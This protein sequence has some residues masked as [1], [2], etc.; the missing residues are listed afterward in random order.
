MTD[1]RGIAQVRERTYFRP[2]SPL[3]FRKYSPLLAVMQRLCNETAHF[4]PATWYRHPSTSIQTSQLHVHIS[5][6]AWYITLSGDAATK[7]MDSKCGHS[8]SQSVFSSELPRIFD[9]D[10]N[11][12]PE[13][14]KR[15]LEF[16]DMTVLYWRNAF[17]SVV[18]AFFGAEIAPL[19]TPFYQ[20][21]FH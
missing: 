20:L 11:A 15:L 7:R 17:L 16:I 9:E 19:L 10:K 21:A 4:F 12:G 1:A 13:R 2:H 6:P 3:W 5:S 8:C 18:Q 14:S